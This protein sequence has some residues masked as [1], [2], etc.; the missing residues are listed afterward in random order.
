MKKQEAGQVKTE[1]D[2]AQGQR[3]KAVDLKAE[4]SKEVYAEQIDILRAELARLQRE[5]MQRAIPV[6]ILFEG[7]GTAGKGAAIESLVNSLDPRGYKVFSITPPTAEDQRYAP[8]YRFAVK[9]PARGQIAIFD[10][11]WYRLAVRAPLRDKLPF[12]K[13]RRLFDT[14][15]AFERQFTDDGG[16]LIKFFLHISEQ[17]QARRI[18][19]QSES[20][21]MRWR[22]TRNEFS[23]NKHYDEYRKQF[24]AIF[25]ATDMP[26][27]RWTILS[28]H[29]KRA[30]YLQ[31][32]QTVISALR[33]AMEGGQTREP[34]LYTGSFKLLP[35]PQIGALPDRREEMSREVYKQKL[36]DLQDEIKKLHGKLYQKKIPLVVVFEGWDA[37]GKGGNIK[38]ISAA[39]DPRGCE[40]I[41]VSAPDAMESAH[42]YLWRFWRSLP[43]TGHVAIFDRSWYGRVLVE[44]VENLCTQEQYMRAYGEINEFESELCM[45]GAEVVKIF[46]NI[47]RN[48]QL[49]RFEA[50]KN[51][52]DKRHKLT[53]EDWR[54]REKWDEYEVAIDDMLRYTNT[55]QAPWHVVDA[56]DE[57]TA[58]IQTLSIVKNAI[59]HILESS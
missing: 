16:V 6:C 10:R 12:A 31:V 23:Q 33:Q 25:S 41:P 44:R 43:R 13:C 5:V 30:L 9:L 35:A 27:A 15:N 20:K 26:A 45:W 37:S 42:H 51:D 55:S 49:M 34:L 19:K 17:E 40:L 28:A 52:P 32:Y 8:L 3:L 59:E 48:T 47:D 22:I 14:V 58:R 4:V 38:R 39:L 46:L 56:R 7:W 1:T 36:D 54:N 18:K 29:N 50:R 53:D 2:T 21:N 24:E 11:S 57:Y